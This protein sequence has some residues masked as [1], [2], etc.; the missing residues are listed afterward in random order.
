[1]KHI[2]LA[3]A[4][5]EELFLMGL[6]S[7]LEKEEDIEVIGTA[8]DGGELLTVFASNASAPDVYVLDLRMKGMDGIETAK[9]LRVKNP[10]A[11]I[12]I[13]SSHYR[14]T[15]LGY[16]LK[17]GVNAFLPKNMSPFQLA[18]AIRKV[19]VKGLF[20]DEQQMLSVHKELSSGKKPVHPTLTVEHEL[21]KRERE[22]LQLI[23]EQYTNPEIAEKLFLSVRTI[24]GHRNNLLQKTGVKNTAGLVLYAVYNHMIR[25]EEKLLQFSFEQLK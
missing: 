14:D 9:Q 20:F 24:E 21:T 5:D 23:C 19:H 6:K 1:M 8:T 10:E 2:K 17:L 3:M 22:I 18:D 11:K 15:F 13:L 7:I 25:W 4:D 12:I 16:M